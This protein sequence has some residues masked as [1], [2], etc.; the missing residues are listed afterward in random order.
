MPSF[1]V[2]AIKSL[3][4]YVQEVLLATVGQKIISDTQNRLFGHIVHQDVALFQSPD[5]RLAGV[6]FHLRYQCHAVPPCSS[7]FVGIGRDALSVI[8]LVGLIFYQDWLLASISLVAAPLS[9]Y[10]LQRLSRRMR[11]VA[12]A[13]PGGDGRAQHLAVADLPGHPGDQ[14]L[15]A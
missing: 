15:W 4:S 6:S 10:P 8:F 13:N 5:L 2:F 14:G 3:T 7:A 1:A 9:I 12:G 11:K